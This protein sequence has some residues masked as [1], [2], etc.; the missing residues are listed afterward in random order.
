MV[1]LAQNVPIGTTQNKE[2]K[3]GES[4]GGRKLLID[5]KSEMKSPHTNC[6]KRKKRIII[7]IIIITRSQ[8]EKHRNLKKK[9]RIIF[10]TF[11]KIINNSLIVLFT[12]EQ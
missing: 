3:T 5:S 6:D 2:E 4:W 7:I 12:A 11:N 10:L 1:K 8:V 9:Q